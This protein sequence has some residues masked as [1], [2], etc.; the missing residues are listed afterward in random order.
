MDREA[1]QAA[2]TFM[3]K[4]LPQSGYLRA[5]RMLITVLHNLYKFPDKEKYRK[6]KTK[7]EVPRDVSLR[8][9]KHGDALWLRKP[10]WL[11]TSTSLVTTRRLSEPSSSWLVWTA[12]CKR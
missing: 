3:V 8:L 7:N 11:T 2:L 4:E 1:Y 12:A 10:S 5:T 9:S 6:L